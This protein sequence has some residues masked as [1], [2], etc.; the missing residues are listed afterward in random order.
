MAE[1]DVPIID[2]TPWR[3]GGEAERAGLVSAV[4]EACMKC[5]FFVIVGHGVERAIIDTMWK[6]RMCELMQAV[7]VQYIC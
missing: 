1:I 5:G 6:V 2:F 4:R 7:C 3:T